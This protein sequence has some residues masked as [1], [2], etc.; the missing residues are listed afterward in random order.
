MTTQEIQTRLRSLGNAET[1]ASAARYFKTAPGQY[2]E[3]DVFL[4]IRATVMHSLAKEYQAI[5]LGVARSLLRSKIHEDRLLALLIL[6]RQFQKGGQTTR[7]RVYSNY[8]AN[9]RYINNW[10]LVDCSARDIVGGYLADRDRSPLDEL[11]RSASLWERRIGIIATAHFIR[12]DEFDD[13]LRIAETLMADR[14][15][16]I[17]KAVGWMLRE[18]GKRDQKT[19]ESFLQRHHRTMPRTM[20]R[21]SIERFPQELR[22][23]YLKGISSV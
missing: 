3:G 14:E 19:L 6:V 4:G 17:H 10:D 12:S 5:P 18:V 1:A 9:T 23:R 7:Q 13:T 11:A 2:G 15:D 16:L 21:Y 8:L 20:L 22:V